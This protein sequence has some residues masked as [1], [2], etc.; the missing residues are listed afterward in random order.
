MM[1]ARIAWVSV[2]VLATSL[3]L[4]AQVWAD[5]VTVREPAWGLPHIFADTD[6]ELARE[7]GR[8]IAK[9]RLGQLILLSRVGRG[10]LNQAFGILDPTTLNDDIEA[11]R[12]AYTSSELNNM[13]AKLPQRE[14]DTV[15]E[16]CKGVNDT[17]D[18]IY[19]GDLPQPLE[20]DTLR[21]VLLLGD[22][23]FGNKNN[24]SDQFD[25]FYAPPG[26]EWPN[27]GFQ[28]TPEMVVAI[29]IL[30]IRNF[31]INDFGEANRITELQNLINV[32]GMM[33]GTEIWDDLNY[34]VD[35]LAPVTVPDPAT[36]GYG[37]PLALRRSPLLLASSAFQFPAYDYA[38][39]TAPLDQAAA[40]RAEFAQRLGA[41]PMLGSY[42]WVIAGNK[43]ASG[44]PWLGGFPQTGIQTP[45]LM[46]FAENRSLEGTE[47]INGIGMEF[48]G[49]PFV[50]I[51]QTDTV[52]Y[53]ST[54][55][56]LRII[57]TVFEKLINEDS[58]VLHYNDMGNTAPL[59]KRTEVFDGGLAPDVTR[60]F[61]RTHERNGNGGSRAVN[62]FIGDRDSTADGG[63][64]T[65]LV[66]AGM[67]D[68]SFI[69]G[70]VALIGRAAPGQTGVGQIRAISAV[71][72]SDT[73]TVGS[74]WTVA[75]DNTFQYVAVRPGKQ[76]VAAAL[77][78]PVWLEETNGAL[79]FL[80]M[81]RSKSIMDI[82]KYARVIPSTHNFPAVDNLPFNGIGTMNG[83]GNIGYWSSGF[84][85]KRQGGLDPRLPIDGTAATNPL[86][87][88]SG[89]V[90]AATDTTSPRRRSTSATTIPARSAASTWP[91]SPAA[92]A[93]SSRAASPATLPIPSRSSS[94]GRWFR[95]P[96]T[97]SRSSRSQACRRPS[98]R[99]KATWRTGTTRR[100]PPTRERTS[101]ASSATSSSSSGWR[102]KTPGI[103]TSSA[104]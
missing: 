36:P 51:G 19:A 23:L 98:T 65:T 12:T 42:A 16:Y 82:R 94:P 88:T 104:S 77:D 15:L 26:G 35:P 63:S 50:L 34:L 93:T 43:S 20:V 45:S 86:V 38:A 29:A 59:V 46:H 57:D 58:D 100:R 90:S 54:T 10:T 32:H 14:R 33:A 96:A 2:L 9:D 99:P 60:T 3:M 22:D 75:P 39:A 69:G 37:G 17:I 4:P 56:Q 76:I 85:R 66:D 27:A 28:F 80:L 92:P 71:P 81:Q 74:P 55:A 6:K 7:N 44:H 78:N 67:F 5:A 103:A 61:W 18:A 79:G 102:R 101:G 1:I 70:Y 68:A 53:T 40:D 41:W 89:T 83:N 48:A 49:A 8:E 91:S 62:D 47:P 95:A 25:P 31:G 84:S 73:L 97:R 30:E 72:D 52:A 11:R 13:Y 64:G 21:I 87:V 24:I